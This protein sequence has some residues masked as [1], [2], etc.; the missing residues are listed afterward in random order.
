MQRTYQISLKMFF[1]YQN[2]G[3][4]TCYVQLSLILAEL[5]RKIDF[6]LMAVL[7][8]TLTSDHFK[9]SF[10]MIK[11]PQN[12]GLDTLIVEL[13][14]LLVEIWRNIHFPVMAS[15]ICIKIVC[16]TFYQIFNIAN[17][18]LWHFSNLETSI[19]NWLP[20]GGCTIPPSS[21]P[22]KL[23]LISPSDT[24]KKRHLLKPN[25]IIPY[26]F[27]WLVTL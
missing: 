15:L 6:S 18:F 12:M 2:I 11:D 24:C 17:R 19:R 4:E 20:G 22:T 13:C 5:W 10:I 3:L 27:E 21:C 7:F 26:M 1:D 14:A 25:Q 8:C 9:N 16:G 23:A